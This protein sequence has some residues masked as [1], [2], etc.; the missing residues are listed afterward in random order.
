M[1]STHARRIGRPRAGSAPGHNG[2][3][4]SRPYVAHR[5]EIP[6]MQDTANSFLSKL[7]KDFLKRAEYGSKTTS[8]DRK[9]TERVDIAKSVRP[10]YFLK[11]TAEGWQP[12]NADGQ[13]PIARRL[14]E[15]LEV[16]SWHDLK[17]HPEASSLLI[18]S[19]G[20]PRADPFP[21]QTCGTQFENLCKWFI[22]QSFIN[23]FRIIR[24]GTFTIRI[25]GALK[26]F[27]Q[28]KHLQDFDEVLKIIP[29]NHEQLKSR[30]QAV[31]A[32]YSVKPDIIIVQDRFHREEVNRLWSA[33]RSDNTDSMVLVGSQEAQKS[34]LLQENTEP[35][36]PLLLHAIISAKWTIR[37][38]RAQN[39][40][41]EGAFATQQRRGR[42]PHFVV[43]TGEPKPSRIRSLAMGADVDCVY[44]ICLP[45]LVQAV[46]EV[47]LQEPTDDVNDQDSG[48]TET[49][50]E[51]ASIGKRTE[52]DW[53]HI[54]L[55]MNRVRDITDLPFDL[56]I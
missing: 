14:A 52:K 25:G 21:G 3:G 49:D 53:M 36:S 26:E 28:Y 16:P 27:D 15:I 29:Q 51:S 23:H 10:F 22:E 42:A 24:P 4:V 8:L 55:G 37:S 41:T 54:L 46:N 30:L 47:G 32:S 7:R 40:R 20:T 18:T 34:P 33:S 19:K 39:A 48:Q 43:V 1:A 2:T 11:A 13:E 35:D 12:S 17:N 56:A 9:G 6:I 50:K 44:H 45:A 5:L 31:F 38:D